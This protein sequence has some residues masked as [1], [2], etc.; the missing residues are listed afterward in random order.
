MLAQ[1]G[2]VG[3]IRRSEGYR[4][5]IGN[6]TAETRVKLFGAQLLTVGGRSHRC[7]LSGAT[8][9]LL[10]YLILFAGKETRRE[11]LADLLWCDSSP[12]QQRSAL[13]SAAWRIRSR[14]RGVSGLELRTDG[15]LIGLEISDEVAVDVVELEEAMALATRSPPSEVLAE[16]LLTALQDCEEP[17]LGGAVPDWAL[18]ERERL[19]SLRLRGLTELMHWRADQKRY[20]DALDLG[21]RLLIADPFREAAQG[22]VMWLYVLNGQR[23]QALKQYRDY[24]ALLL[25]ELDIEPMPET[26]ALYEHIRRDLDG[27]APTRSLAAV[28]DPKQPGQGTA[29]E[30][31]LG[32]IDRSRRDLYDALRGHAR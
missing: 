20:E 3:E 16:R 11:R 10:H 24:A 31:M 8:R 6:K 30:A 26:R 17:F 18:A 29:L 25:A 1:P 4:L 9:D 23:V 21:R 32:A 19:F 7:T 2:L 28:R 14:L 22:Q 13:N 12:A 15:E 5:V 27:G